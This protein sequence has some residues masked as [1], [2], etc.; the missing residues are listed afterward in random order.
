MKGKALI[1]FLWWATHEGQRYAS[2]LLYAP[3]PPAAVK[4]IEG[5]I[6]EIAYD[7]KPLFAAR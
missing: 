5:K 2:D 7:G 4:Q 1:S 3:L 6:R